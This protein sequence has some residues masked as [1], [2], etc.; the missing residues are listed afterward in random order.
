VIATGNRTQPKADVV[1]NMRPAAFVDDYLPYF[2][3]IPDSVH[4]ALVLRA[5]NGSPNTGPELASVGSIH[6]NL[7]EFSRAWLSR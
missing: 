5:P 2:R 6:Q 1:E 7:A 4:K 3:G